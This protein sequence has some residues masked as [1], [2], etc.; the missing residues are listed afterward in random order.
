MKDDL[1]IIQHLDSNSKYLHQ[2]L[3]EN[4]AAQ[5]DRMDTISERLLTLELAIPAL[6][7]TILKLT[8]G[9]DATLKLNWVFYLTFIC[10][11]VALVLTWLAIIP[12]QWKVD[13]T[14]L[15]QDPDLFNEALGIEDFFNKTAS[16]KRRLTIASSM[17]VF[18]GVIFAVFTIG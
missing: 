7:A 15:K 18:L 17:F 6:Y 4:I 9:E 11:G 8:A 12:K 2:K 5:S 14:I 3:Y 13:E 16:Y 1:P 10:W